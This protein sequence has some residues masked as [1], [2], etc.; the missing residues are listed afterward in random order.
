MSYM[1]ENIDHFLEPASL[2]GPG[3]TEP[4]QTLEAYLDAVEERWNLR[5]DRD[6]KELG[7]GLEKLMEH[8]QVSQGFLS[9][10][11]IIS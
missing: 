7:D 3:S 10:P 4:A 5:I 9:P 2:P 1:S 6:V 8:F 11:C